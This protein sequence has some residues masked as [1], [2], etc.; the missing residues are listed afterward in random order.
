[1]CPW[2]H[3]SED[4]G[5]SGSL[6]LPGAA[7]KACLR[8]V[9]A[10]ESGAK[11]REEEKRTLGRWLEHLPPAMPEAIPCMS[12]IW[13]NKSLHLL[14]LL[15]VIYPWFCIQ[16]AAIKG[17][18]RTLEGKPGP[19]LR[20][21]DAT[22]K[23]AQ[24]KL[25]GMMGSIILVRAPTIGRARVRGSVCHLHSLQGPHSTA[26]KMLCVCTGSDYFTQTCSLSGCCGH[27]GLG[28]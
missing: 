25:P 13:A 12:V 22:E 19:E 23:D 15:F 5:G 1:M 17:Q 2:D 8:R 18:N 14:L 4:L 26:P 27:L 20:S 7:Q 9:S 11:K 16:Q 3:N 10:E 21:K 28:S 24:R 6:T